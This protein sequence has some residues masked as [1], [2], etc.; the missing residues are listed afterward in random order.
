[1]RNFAGFSVAPNGALAYWSGDPGFTQLTLVSREGAALHPIGEPGIYLYFNLSHDERQV[2]LTAFGVDSPTTDVWLMDVERG[3]SSRFTSDPAMEQNAYWSP[4]DK[5]IVFS[6][7][8]NG[9]F[10]LYRKKLVGGQE[11]PVGR[12]NQPRW[13]SGWSANGNL[14]LFSGPSSAISQSDV[15]A[16]PASGGDPLLL[17]NTQFDEYSASASPNGRWLAFVSNDTG[18]YEVYVQSFPKGGTRQRISTGGG[19]FPQW[20]ADGKELYYSTPDNT[21]MA[22]EVHGDGPEFSTGT[23]NAL[24]P[25]KAAPAF[26]LGTFW[27]PMRNGQRFLV[28]R[29]AEP[30]QGKP[31]T[32][33][34]NWQAALKK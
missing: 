19:F 17:A 29:P 30:A 32:I 5:E 7:T 18:A 31:I 16:I 21:L 12:S 25:L 9:P 26:S 11:E 3:V 27:Q 28:L 24:F 34:T 15:W 2:A 33:V 4:D 13:A 20:R 10:N 6:S 8:R 22:V 1:V 14:L 23:P